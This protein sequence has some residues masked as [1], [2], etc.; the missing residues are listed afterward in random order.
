MAAGHHGYTTAR[1]VDDI[2]VCPPIPPWKGFLTVAH[3]VLAGLLDIADVQVDRILE[4]LR[5]IAARGRLIT[6]RHRQA[7]A[8]QR[9]I[10]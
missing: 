6:R 1:N 2:A 4:E 3:D 9:D 7:A 10:L 8:S 5:R